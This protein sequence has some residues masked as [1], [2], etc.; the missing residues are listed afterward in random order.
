M[1]KLLMNATVIPVKAQMETAT[2]ADTVSKCAIATK[3]WGYPTHSHFAQEKIKKGMA[4]Q[5]PF[6]ASE[7]A[8]KWLPSRA[9]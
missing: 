4:D 5:M 1:A 3:S 2:I 9:P 7:A 6:I 8:R